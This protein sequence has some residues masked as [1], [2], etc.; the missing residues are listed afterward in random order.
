MTMAKQYRPA[1]LTRKQQDSIGYRMKASLG[2]HLTALEL[3]AVLTATGDDEAAAECL[4]SAREW[5]RKYLTL[6]DRLFDSV[7]PFVIAMVASKWSRS[8]DFRDLQNEACARVVRDLHQFNPAK[9]K[10]TTF[11]GW[12]IYGAESN[13]LRKRWMIHI[14]VHVLNAINQIDMGN[15]ILEDYPEDMQGRIRFGLSAQQ[16]VMISAI[17]SGEPRTF[18]KRCA[19]DDT[20]EEIEF[21][22]LDE[23]RSALV[24]LTDRQREVLMHR[25]GFGG[26]RELTLAETGREL[27]LTRERIR[28]IEK[29]AYAR[30]RAVMGITK[31]CN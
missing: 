21:D 19:S 9:G 23:L 11:V 25:H 16:S 17:P 20:R 3:H 22:R 5:G 7:Y 26:R 2:L 15:A 10:L 24:K 18:T 31:S 6:R 28:Q 12:R 4:A 8:R 1:K 30:L 29:D 13:Y 14:P 27:G